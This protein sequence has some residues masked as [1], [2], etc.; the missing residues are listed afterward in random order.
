MIGTAIAL[1][2]AVISS[3]VKAFRIKA[4]AADADADVD[5]MEAENDASNLSL[6]IRSRI[7]RGRGWVTRAGGGN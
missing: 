4:V 5:A 1:K 2:F 3:I 7:D 6:T